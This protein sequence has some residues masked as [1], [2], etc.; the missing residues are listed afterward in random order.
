MELYITKIKAEVTAVLC[1]ERTKRVPLFIVRESLITFFSLML[2]IINFYILNCNCSMHFYVMI[3][4]TSWTLYII[5]THILR[6]DLY[7]V[8]IIYA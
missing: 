8:H 2:S 4:L 6:V 1:S 3:K 5:F 7:S